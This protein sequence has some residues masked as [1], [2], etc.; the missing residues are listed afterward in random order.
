M[1]TFDKF[2]TTATLDAAHSSGVEPF[3]YQRRR[4]LDP[5]CRS[6]RTEISGGWCKT[7]AAV[8]AKS[9]SGGDSHA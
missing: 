9:P 4:A 8:L 7:A 3:N 2:F 6:R 5:E 1:M